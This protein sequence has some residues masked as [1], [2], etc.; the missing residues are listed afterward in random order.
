MPPCPF[1]H[2][3]NT[4]VAGDRSWQEPIREVHMFISVS[5]GNILVLIGNINI[6]QLGIHSVRP[7]H[8]PLLLDS[9]QFSNPVLKHQVKPSVIA[10][11]S[12]QNLIPSNLSLSLSLQVK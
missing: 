11:E 5:L 12:M 9:C 7:I 6:F 2:E 8:I 4:R 3:I 1:V 10:N